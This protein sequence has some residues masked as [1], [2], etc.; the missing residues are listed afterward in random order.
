ML[1]ESRVIGQRLRH[2]GPHFPAKS[3][4]PDVAAR[5]ALGKGWHDR[6]GQLTLLKDGQTCPDGGGRNDYNM[7]TYHTQLPAGSCKANEHLSF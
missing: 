6:N 1:G 4:N 7:V 2:C 3:N 5:N